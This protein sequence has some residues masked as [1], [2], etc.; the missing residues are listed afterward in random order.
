MREQFRWM[1][2]CAIAVGLGVLVGGGVACNGL[3][4]GGAA[5][6]GGGPPA[7][8]DW[9]A[10]D[11]DAGPVV[12]LPAGMAMEPTL[13]ADEGIARFPIVVGVGADE[14]IWEAAEDLALY[15]ETISGAPFDVVEGDGQEGLVLGEPDDFEALAVPDVEFGEGPLEQEDYAMRSHETQGLYLLGASPLAVQFAVWDLLYRLG[16]RQFFPTETWEVV[17]ERERIEVAIDIRESPD[18]QSRQAPRPPMRLDQRPWA[19]EPWERWQIRNRTAATFELAT[20]HAYDTVIAANQEA[21]DANPDYWGLVDGE[22][23]S[24][25]QPNIAHP[26]VQQMFVDYA[27][28]RL[29]DD[30]ERHSVAIDPRDGPF[31]S[32]GAASQA[33]GGPSEQAVHLANT[34]AEAVEAAHGDE[35]YVGMYGYSHHSPPPS[36][37]VH[38]NVIVSLATAFIR[39]G[40]TFDE[41]LTGWSE[42]AQY[43]GIREYYSLWEWDYS[44][45][46]GGGRAS[47]RAYLQETIPHFYEQGARFINAESSDAWGP[48]GLGYY[49]ASRMLWDVEEADDMEALVDDFLVR[50]FGPAQEVMAEFYDL[51]DGDAPDPI[52]PQHR[53]TLNED[54]VAMMYR[55][56]DAARDQA[57][58]HDAI[59]ARIDDLILYTRYVELYRHFDGVRGPE[60]QEAFDALISFSW[61][62]RDTLMTENIEMTRNIDY[63]VRTDEHLEWGEGYS[64]NEPA[65]RHRTQEDEPFSEQEIV[66]LLEGGMASNQPLELDVDPWQDGGDVAPSGLTPDLRGQP[67]TTPNRGDIDALIQTDDGILP[68]L[69]LSAGHVYDDRGPLQWD[70]LDASGEVIDSGEVAPDETVHSFDLEASPGVYHL[71]ITNTG[72]GFVWDYEPHGARLTLLA[73]GSHSLERNYFDRLYFYVPQGTDEVVLAGT[74]MEERH[75]FFDGAG[76]PL[77][78]DAIEETQGYTVV[79]VPPG[80]DG[81]VWSL[82]TT[83]I[84]IDLS[85]VNTPGYVA[86]SPDELLLPVELEG[87]L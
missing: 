40:Y 48:F 54:T 61:R 77:S 3:D 17:P 66:D 31:W 23:S 78:A 35:T 25:A 55:L 83:A 52:N 80:Q 5:M 53:R 26:D 6:D 24:D 62:I 9:L 10:D 14:M 72:Q 13:L 84:R 85:F 58:D 70:L 16:H 67:G 68:T 1:R 47:R 32:E 37:D 56:L 38:P 75:A 4:G 86:L 74:L 7:S 63:D 18:Y 71:S 30:P 21:F 46:A 44:L 69:H 57:D 43:I 79:P 34:V 51:I 22:R 49:L 76:Q 41:M 2:K 36:I 65:D 11:V 50:A 45:P 87:E 28:G 82:E 39:E 8:G 81:Q 29:D 42:R 73:G 64:R 20:G 12:D 27:L 59:I 33:I 19:E 60:R 15:L